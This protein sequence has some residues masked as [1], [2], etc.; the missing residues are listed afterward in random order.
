M[1]S[2]ADDVIQRLRG[3]ERVKVFDLL[4]S[5]STAPVEQLNQITS[6]A[7]ASQV[8]GSSDREQRILR[9]FRGGG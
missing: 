7:D 6:Y 2:S 3:R 1:K 5:L 9:T 8:Y 4:R